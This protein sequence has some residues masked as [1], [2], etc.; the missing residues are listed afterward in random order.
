MTEPTAMLAVAE[1]DIKVLGNLLPTLPKHIK[2][3]PDAVAT[4]LVARELGLA[5]MSSFP[6]LMVING[7]VGMTSKLMLGLIYKA[8]HRVDIVEMSA[9]KAH[10]V[11]H[12]YQHDE[13]HEVGTFIF[14]MDDAEVA[15]LDGKETYVQYPADMLMNKAVAR[16]ARFAFPDIL[17][18]YVPDEV[19]DITGVEF[20]EDA[21]HLG[22]TEEVLTVEEVA[23]LLDG[24][25]VEDAT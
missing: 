9:T 6:D 1:S 22:P 2:S 15:L 24:E 3:V 23:E 12:R 4:M 18:G 11:A 19:E 16:A 13:W 5:P 20:E 21:I 10:V 7:T 17:R 25:V 14:T 8:G